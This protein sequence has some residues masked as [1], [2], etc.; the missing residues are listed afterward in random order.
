MLTI[1][2]GIK[3][4]E[5]WLPIADLEGL[6]VRRFSAVRLVR[7]RDLSEEGIEKGGSVLFFFL[8]D[9]VVVGFVLRA[10]FGDLDMSLEVF[11]VLSV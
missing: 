3:L 6:G 7:A 2:P 4:G 1:T 5:L 10:L 8:N 11:D 9:G